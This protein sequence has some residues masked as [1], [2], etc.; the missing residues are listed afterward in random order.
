MPSLNQT[1][2]FQN[3]DHGSEHYINAPRTAN[4]SLNIS[5]Q[6]MRTHLETHHIIVLTAKN[7][8]TVFKAIKMIQNDPYSQVPNRPVWLAVNTNNPLTE[9]SNGR[10]VYRNSNAGV[11]NMFLTDKLE[12]TPNP[13]NALLVNSG[14]LRYA[15]APTD[16]DDPRASALFNTVMMKYKEIQS[17]LVGDSQKEE[18]TKELFAQY[19]KG[20]K[21]LY[22]AKVLAITPMIFAGDNSLS[23]AIML[24]NTKKS[25]NPFFDFE[26]VA[27]TFELTNLPVQN[28][29]TGFIATTLDEPEDDTIEVGQRKLSDSRNEFVRMATIGDGYGNTSSVAV[30]MRDLG[31]TVS[32]KTRKRSEVFEELTETGQYMYIDGQLNMYGN[33]VSIQLNSYTLQNAPKSMD[34]HTID[35]SDLLNDFETEDSVS[36]VF[37]VE[38]LDEMI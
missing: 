25:N 31:Y 13:Y 22:D 7:T 8:L 30:S 16:K 9:L 20:L 4:G 27:K 29:V 36:P 21:R 26:T 24:T 5:V 2:D 23:P 19:Q 3:S 37:S 14:T 34:T 35:V 15:L 17:M 12:K 32:E 33:S 1:V 10:K 18:A 6:L 11:L 38:E 28:S